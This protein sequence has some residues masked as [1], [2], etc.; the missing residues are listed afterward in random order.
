MPSTYEFWL[1]D[2][3]GRRITLLNN[4]AYFSYSRAVKG[5]GTIDIGIP[6][7][8]FRQKVFP[9]FQP[10]WR[11][12]VWRSPDKGF[13]L[14]RE[15]T[16]LLR[17]YKIYTRE[18]DN[19]QILRFY[20][21]SLK[22]LLRRRYVIQPAGYS[23]TYKT[24]Y[25]DDMM[26]E[27]VKEQ[28]LYGSVLDADAVL[29]NTRAFPNGEFFVQGDVSLGPYYISTFPDRQVLDVLRELQDASIQLHEENP[30][31]NNRIYFD[32][33][34]QDIEGFLNYILAEDGD[35]ILD[36]S[37]EPL[38]DEGSGDSNIAQTL[39]FMT[40]ADLRG[41]DRTA[42]AL[43][44]STD[45][46]NIEQPYYS[47]TYME[48]ENSIVVKGFGRG[49]SRPSARVTDTQRAGASRWN[50]CEGLEDASTEP[51]QD[52]L[53]YYAY[54]RLRE[55]DVN[56]SLSVVFLNVPGSEDTP[57][58]LYGVDWDLGDLLPVAYI[59]KQF[60]VEVSIVYVAID[61]NGRE[62]ITGRNEVNASDQA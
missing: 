37:G 41:Q 23:Q 14:R 53:E 29:D 11:I 28:M 51:D 38:Y 13:N 7:R 49:D 1:L 56:E 22:D 58:S 35:P 18:T 47:K 44:F 40:F 3:H 36:E 45:N 33:I 4:L 25:I 62:T 6:Y 31:I 55:N 34:P 10:D 8:E 15:A 57:R 5:Y 50:F 54:P 52:N 12:D 30:L 19:I 60:N 32:I 59:G 9:I 61:E 27:I 2:D 43:I 17:L 24:D 16:Y 21:R 46:A 42:S 39:K 48:E 20:G 26:K